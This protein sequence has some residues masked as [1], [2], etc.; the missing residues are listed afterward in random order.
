M[1]EN[2]VVILDRGDYTTCAVNLHGAV[3]TSWRINNKEQIFVSRKSSLFYLSEIRGGIGV[4]FPKLGTWEFGR[5][6]G[7]ARDLTWKIK[8]GPTYNRKEDVYAEFVLESDAYT[9]SLWNYQFKLMNRVTLGKETLF[10]EFHVENRSNYLPFYFDFML[11]F[12][13]KI[14]DISKCRI[15]GLKGCQFRDRLDKKKKYYNEDRSEITISNP[16][17]RL[18]LNS[19]TTIYV[20]DGDFGKVTKLR[21][22][23]LPN[24]NLWNPWVD[25]ARELPDLGDEEYRYFISPESCS[26]GVFLPPMSCWKASQLID[27]TEP[28]DHQSTCSFYDIFDD[29]C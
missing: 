27:V 26:E 24:L 13:M 19:S 15:I 25:M 18:Y 29:Y 5:R 8:T 14:S 20:K 2:E 11:R 12:L 9:E 16:V 22:R 4:A 6:H 23:N 28:V 3:V 1:K 21:R 7:F 17:D 10:I